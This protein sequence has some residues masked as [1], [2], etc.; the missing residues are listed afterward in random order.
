MSDGNSLYTSIKCLKVFWLFF[1][2]LFFFFESGSYYVAQVVL[3]L[4]ILLPQSLE[5][6]DYMCLKV[7][8]VKTEK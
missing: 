1:S 7:L 2:F 6:W 8:M 5:C 4:K 3:K